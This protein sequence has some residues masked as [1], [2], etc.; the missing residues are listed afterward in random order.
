MSSQ[1]K[2]IIKKSK[3]KL[4]IEEN[5]FRFPDEL[6]NVIKDF[7]G[8]FTRPQIY[9]RWTFSGKL[10]LEIRWKCEKC[11]KEMKTQHNPNTKRVRLLLNEIT[12][13]QLCMKCDGTWEE[14]LKKIF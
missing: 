12:S 2:I 11:E 6:W 13:H 1:N 7:V 3:R 8:F 5:E 4:I 9:P 14:H 10:C